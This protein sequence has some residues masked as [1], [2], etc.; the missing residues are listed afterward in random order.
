MVLLSSDVSWWRKVI[1]HCDLCLPLSG[2]SMRR[3]HQLVAAIATM[4]VATTS[5][6]F[7]T[8][9]K[10]EHGATFKEEG[11]GNDDVTDSKIF[12]SWWLLPSTTR[13][14]NKF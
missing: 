9:T 6:F 4:L 13:P 3:R 12:I 10:P 11:F 1:N 2:A 7:Q 14:P 5:L 8:T